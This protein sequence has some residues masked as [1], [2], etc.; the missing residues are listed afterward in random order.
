MVEI[1]AKNELFSKTGRNAN[2][3]TSTLGNIL[4]RIK[5]KTKLG[6][7]FCHELDA[8]LFGSYT[9]TYTDTRTA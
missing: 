6:Q 2:N 3:K 9:S 4:D 8:D 1:R 7:L 5:L